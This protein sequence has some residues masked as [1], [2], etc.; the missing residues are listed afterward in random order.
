MP[1]LRPIMIAARD[2]PCFP[3]YGEALPLK[4]S[5]PRVLYETTGRYTV[6]GAGA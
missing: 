2:L 6:G 4:G 5:Q 3:H 1:L